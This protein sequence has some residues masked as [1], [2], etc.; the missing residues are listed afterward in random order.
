[1]SHVYIEHGG[2][3]DQRGTGLGGIGE[4]PIFR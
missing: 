2:L 1:M 3:L 4:E